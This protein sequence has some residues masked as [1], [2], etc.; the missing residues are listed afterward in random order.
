MPW[1]T[2]QTNPNYESK[3]IEKIGIV[4]NEMNLD[5]IREIFSPE[6]TIVEYKDGKKKERKKKLYSNYLFIEMDYSDKVWHSLKKIKGVVGFVGNRT[7]P[8][9]VPLREIKTM[10]DRISVDSPKPKIIYEVE[11]K[12]RIKD[13]SFADFQGI[14][15]SV[16]YE[17]NKAKVA[18]NIFNRETIVDLDLN[19]IEI[20][21]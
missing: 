4:K 14:V 7:N 20:A 3:V 15:R 1:Y 13:G 16:D 18:V 12:V 19:M 6:E 2:L 5:Q 17:K 8:V 9:E 21:K 11:S 10:K